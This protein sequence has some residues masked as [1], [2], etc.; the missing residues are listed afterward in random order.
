MA[1]SFQR[2]AEL[3]GNEYVSYETL[4]ACGR[5]ITL[6][7]QMNGLLVHARALGHKEGPVSRA[8]W[9][10]VVQAARAAL[11]AF[12]EAWSRYKS[13]VTGDNR[14]DAAVPLNAAIRSTLHTIEELVANFPARDQL[15]LW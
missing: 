6:D 8:D 14:Q 9:V 2:Y 15:I 3:L 12:D 4:A 10:A 13:E 7:A 1:T 5:L 11:S